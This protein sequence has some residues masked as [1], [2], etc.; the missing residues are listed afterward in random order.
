[1]S[2]LFNKLVSG[3]TR[4]SKKLRCE[5]NRQADFDKSVLRLNTVKHDGK[6][7]DLCSTHLKVYEE[8]VGI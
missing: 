3:C 5:L 8:L 6:F 2:Y 7:F 4:S 1:V